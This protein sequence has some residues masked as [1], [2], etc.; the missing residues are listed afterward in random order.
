MVGAGILP[1]ALRHFDYL[2]G[3]VPVFTVRA[4]IAAMS[5]QHTTFG[6]QIRHWRGQRR[7]SQLHL[8]TDARISTRHL[9]F[10]ETGRSRPSRG[11]V[12]H[13]AELLDVPLRER[14]GLL[15][16]AGFSPAFPVNALDS[17]ALAAAMAAVDLV[18]DAHGAFPA[19][20]VDRHWNLLRA[21]VAA[22]RL[23]HSIAPHLLAP[24]PNVLR[25]T[26]SP[27]GLAPIIVN[28][29]QLREHM[30]GR[31]LRQTRS[32]GDAQLL[33][34][35][36]ELSQLPDAGQ[37]ENAQ[38]ATPDP[39]V[40][41]PMR[42]RTPYG[43]LSVFSTITIFGTPVDVTLSELAIEAFFPSDE[44]SRRLLEQ[45]HTAARD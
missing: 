8:A 10:I 19:L 31:L 20:A 41:I 22:K 16:A 29:A 26:F 12:L 34:L 15:L 28:L 35:Y 3:H 6:Q 43:E 45:L 44:A 13:L 5:S 17:Q 21:N 24:K 42:M 1:M 40:V 36:E 18:L 11:M 33:A 32:T 9:S 38:I 39:D 4:S 2:S 7:L 23:M 37:D 30:L 14:N 25:M 27:D